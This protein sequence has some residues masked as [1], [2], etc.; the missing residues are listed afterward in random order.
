MG[1]SVEWYNDDKT[2]IIQNYDGRWSWEEFHELTNVIVPAMMR[3]VPHTVHIFSD[4]T[5]GDIPSMNSALTH[6]KHALSSFGDNWGCLVVVGGN[7]VINMLV[8]LFRQLFNN[9]VGSKTFAAPTLD[10]ALDLVVQYQAN[11]EVSPE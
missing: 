2:I 1:I 5:N 11:M 10:I 4:F 6:A 3:E 9:S 7:S 8:N